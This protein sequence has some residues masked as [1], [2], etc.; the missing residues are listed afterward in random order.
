VILSN[1]SSTSVKTVFRDPVKI[2]IKEELTGAEVSVKTSDSAKVFANNQE[3]ES[4]SLPLIG[5][6]CMNGFG[7]NNA[8]GYKRVFL[9][10][11]DEFL[12]PLYTSGEY[13]N[14]YIFYGIIRASTNN[15]IIPD[16]VNYITLD[17]E[18]LNAELLTS[19][20][21]KKWALRVSLYIPSIIMIAGGIVWLRRRHL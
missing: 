12:S 3:I 9:I 18:S 10:G 6:Y 2:K 5:V 11:S 8:M 19:Q 1:V 15:E 17:N 4:G 14:P 13:G 7:K 16:N 20:V 21:A